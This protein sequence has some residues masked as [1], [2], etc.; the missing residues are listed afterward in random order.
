MYAIKELV[1]QSPQGLQRQVA[2]R[3]KQLRLSKN[4]TRAVLSNQSGVPEPTIKRFEASGEISIK[5]LARLA[6]FLDAAAGF[7]QLFQLP[8]IRSL[9]ELSRAPKRQR[10]R[11][12]KVTPRTAS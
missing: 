2:A 10:A 5:S 8:E 11:R 12:S 7:T 6:F 9:D 1:D 3:F 4:V